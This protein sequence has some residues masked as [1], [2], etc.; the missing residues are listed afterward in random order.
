[1]SKTVAYPLPAIGMD[2]LSIQTDLPAGA[3]RTATNVDIGRKGSFKRRPGFSSVLTDAGLHSMWY[4]PQK[5]WTLVAKNAQL[6]KVTFTGTPPS[7]AVLTPLFTLGS[8]NAVSYTEYNGNLYFANRASIGWVP[9]TG[10]PARA[11]GVPAP[12]PPA[13]SVGNGNLLPGTH[14]VVVTLIDERGEEGPACEV[15]TIGLPSGGGITLSGLPLL[16]DWHI[17]V[18]VTS[19]DGDVLRLAETIPAIFA[20]YTIGN[21]SEGGECETQFLAPL[22]PGDFIRWHAGRLYTAANGV[23]RFS[24]AGRPHLSNPATD[25]IPFSGHIAFIEPVVDG[26]YVADSRGVWFLSG[27]DPVKFEKRRVSNYRAVA[28]SSLLV[29]SANLPEKLAE[30]GQSAAVWLSEHGYV[31]GL[32]GGQ[33]QELQPDRLKLTTG[34]TGRSTFV[35]REGRKQIITP[36]NSTTTTVLGSAV[37]SPIP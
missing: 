17:A 23:L 4:A 5:G 36:V 30:G 9:S 37:D 3:V 14:A 12:S 27:N 29:S 18:Y 11:V 2:M 15:Q 31:A 10:G 13:L 25:F 8:A 21:Q 16:T 7:A 19:A 32:P 34:L 33:V 22:P 28:Y 26:I 20:T 24:Q 1:M 35:L 6:N